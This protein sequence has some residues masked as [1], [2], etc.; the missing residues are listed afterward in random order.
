MAEKKYSVAKL[1][2]IIS[3]I[4]QKYHI[5]KAC[6]FGSFARGDY[7]GQSDIDLRIEKGDLKGLFSLCGFYTDV[8]EKLKTEVDI[9]TTG[10]LERDFLD[11]IR[12]DE[13]ILYER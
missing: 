3:P 8:K 9:L 13:V 2:E 6:L 5:S 1:K 11:R 4:A 10:S 12:D 7:D